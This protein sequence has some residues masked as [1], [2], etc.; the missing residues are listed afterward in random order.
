MRLVAEYKDVKG[1]V[2][3]I[4]KIANLRIKQSHF[5]AALYN[6]NSDDILN[7]DVQHSTLKTSLREMIMEIKT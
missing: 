3:N 6:D 1:N 7:L 5:L 4:K 2:N